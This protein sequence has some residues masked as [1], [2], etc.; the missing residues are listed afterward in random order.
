VKN[1]KKVAIILC[2]IC[3]LG[4]VLSTEYH[5]F[6]LSNTEIPKGSAVIDGEIDKVWDFA[7]E[8]IMIINFQKGKESETA[9]GWARLM[10]DEKNLYVL[11]YV[12]DKTPS[13]IAKIND[14]Y[15]DS[16]E[17]FIDEQNKHIAIDK[18]IDQF[19]TDRNK[20]LS[21][22]IGHKLSSQEELKKTY[23][24][25]EWAVK[26]NK[27]KGEYIVEFKIPWVKITPQADK[28][29]IG[30]AFQIN[31]D[32]NNDGIILDGIVQSEVIDTWDPSTY[33]E[34]KLV[35]HEAKKPSDN[36]DKEDSSKNESNTS[37]DE[38][39]SKDNQTQTNTSSNQS[40]V[41]SSDKN[42]S[43]NKENNSDKENS[44]EKNQT[45]NDSNKD[46]SKENVSSDKNSSSN[47][48]KNDSPKNDVNDKNDT[49]QKEDV[50]DKDKK[51]QEDADN[52]EAESNDDNV[53]N[54]EGT[55]NNDSD[56][57]VETEEN[58]TQVENNSEKENIDVTAITEPVNE[59][60]LNT[61][62]IAS[63]AAVVIVGLICATIIIVAYKKK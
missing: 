7:S 52:N 25:I 35:S 44:S 10:W 16:F 56:T 8:K 53:S 42:E 5:T 18:F 63:I 51:P 58:Q 49:P 23:K 57:D 1:L 4:G 59:K 28:T 3:F 29:K 46:S 15:T 47:K 11:G 6:A 62:I 27:S 48:D 55:E 20:K 24:N 41:T 13:Y 19:R 50:S 14:W 9:S 37:K 61:V 33:P 43:D 45:D 32:Y 54:E 17:F 31:D 40:S 22:M 12:A 39:D 34:F 21:G 36:N 30:V 26:E 60:V 38:E 2:L